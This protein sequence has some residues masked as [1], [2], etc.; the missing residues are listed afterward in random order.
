MIEG[1]YLKGGRK[2]MERKDRKEERLMG[3]KER[4]GRKGEG[5]EVRKKR[6]KE[7]EEKIVYEFSIAKERQGGTMKRKFRRK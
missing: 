4:E 2:V 6:R 3:G 1:N 5:E 7:I